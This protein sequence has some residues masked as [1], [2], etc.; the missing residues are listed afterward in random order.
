MIAT[1]RRLKAEIVVPI[2]TVVQVLMTRRHT[3]YPPARIP[4]PPQPGRL[5]MEDDPG[6]DPSPPR[7]RVGFR[8][9]N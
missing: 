9:T 1:G 7:S 3:E 2:G 4:H 6:D 8:S 5:E